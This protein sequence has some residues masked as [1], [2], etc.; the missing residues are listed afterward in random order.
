MSKIRDT[1]NRQNVSL[2]R[3]FADRGDALV[4]CPF[5]SLSQIFYACFARENA[6]GG[7]APSVCA[8]KLGVCRSR[9]DLIAHDSSSVRRGRRRAQI[10]RKMAL[11]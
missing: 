3:A 1:R 8:A 5:A 4:A 2:M 7:H 10:E 11:T 9:R 6:A